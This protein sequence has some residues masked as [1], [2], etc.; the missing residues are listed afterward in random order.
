MVYSVR[1]VSTIG[2][3]SGIVC[4]LLKELLRRDI[5]KSPPGFDYEYTTNMWIKIRGN[6]E[7]EEIILQLKLKLK[8]S[9]Y[10]TNFND[11]IL[12]MLVER[13]F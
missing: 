6:F 13:I 2:N 4:Q 11:K 1:P 3:E 8:L 9:I 12:I 10:L 7:L 5:L